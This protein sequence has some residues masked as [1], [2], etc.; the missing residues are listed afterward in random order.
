MPGTWKGQKR[1]LDLLELEVEI[2]M[3]QHVSS[4]DQIQGLFKS[5]KYSKHL[6]H[7]SSPCSFSLEHVSIATMHLHHF[8]LGYE[9]SKSSSTEAKL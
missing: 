2:I 3:N 1:T 6:S 4:G 8:P 9:F 5:I 7:L